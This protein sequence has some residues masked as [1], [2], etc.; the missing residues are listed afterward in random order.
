ML[1]ATGIDAVLSSLT[2]SEN[3]AA[4]VSAGFASTLIIQRELRLIC[5]ALHQRATPALPH[6]QLQYAD[7]SLWQDR[8]SVLVTT[9]ASWSGGGAS[10][11]APHSCCTCRWTIRDN[12]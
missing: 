11:M 12:Q 5:D 10:F 7:F 9:T 3:V 4:A 8:N 2:E 6:L 1:G